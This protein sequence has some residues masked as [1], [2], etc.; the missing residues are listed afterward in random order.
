MR[1]EGMEVKVKSVDRC[2]KELVTHLKIQKQKNRS[3]SSKL[4]LPSFDSNANL[5]GFSQLISTTEDPTLPFFPFPKNK[6]KKKKS[7]R[8]RYRHHHTPRLLEPQPLPES[9]L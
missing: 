1:I 7:R 5:T 6:K 2:L 9:F 8:H 4:A 3:N